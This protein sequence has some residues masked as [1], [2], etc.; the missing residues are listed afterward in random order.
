MIRLFCSLTKYISSKS[1]ITD[2]YN[3]EKRKKNKNKIVLLYFF[4]EFTTF[5][6]DARSFQKIKDIKIE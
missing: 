3:M 6:L 5:A 1:E 4:V 2:K